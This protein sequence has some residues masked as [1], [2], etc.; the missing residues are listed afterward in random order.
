MGNLQLSVR[1]ALKVNS[2]V[3]ASIVSHCKISK[4]VLKSKIKNNDPVQILKDALQQKRGLGVRNIKGKLAV[5]G[6]ND[7]GLRH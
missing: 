5:T 1:K 7:K 4:M 2:S 6:L 3:S